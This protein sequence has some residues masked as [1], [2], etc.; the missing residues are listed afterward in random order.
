MRVVLSCQE[1]V[2]ADTAEGPP[3]LRINRNLARM[4]PF[5]VFGVIL[6]ELL[7]LVCVEQELVRVACK[8]GVIGVKVV[9]VAVPKELRAL[10]CQRCRIEL[11]AARVVVFGDANQLD[12]GQLSIIR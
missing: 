9:D 10:A 12:L 2:R 4:L 8:R 5:T 11:C 6:E 7:L 3:S 1:L